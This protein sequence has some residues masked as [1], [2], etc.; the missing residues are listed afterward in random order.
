M[1]SIGK[2]KQVTLNIPSQAQVRRFDNNAFGP[3]GISEEV[4]P[5]TYRLDAPTYL[6]LHLVSHFA[7]EGLVIMSLDNRLVPRK[8]AITIWG[9]VNEYVR[10]KIL[11]EGVTYRGG[12][13]HT[14]SF[15]KWECHPC[16]VHYRN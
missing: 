7:H 9:M 3:F 1:V 8:H 16:M 15:V 5:L 11:C 10:S 6:N 4:S 14:K 2:R 13:P 12:Y